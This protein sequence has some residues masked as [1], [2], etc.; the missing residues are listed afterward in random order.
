MRKLRR[1]Q[2]TYQEVKLAKANYKKSLKAET[3]QKPI[4]KNK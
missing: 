2:E 4:T 1:E 3:L